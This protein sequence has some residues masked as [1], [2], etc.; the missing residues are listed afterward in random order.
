MHRHKGCET[1][2]QENAQKNSKNA[3]GQVNFM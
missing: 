2:L 1:G 3:E